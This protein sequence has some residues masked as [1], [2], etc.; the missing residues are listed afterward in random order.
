MKI[1]EQL[2]LENQ[3]CFSVYAVSRGIIKLYKQYL[4]KLDLTYTQY[5]TM[6]VLWERG[7][8]SSKELGS[9]LYLDSGTLTLLLK[10]LEKKGFV[11]RRRDI[12]DERILMVKI[13]GK[14]D[15]LKE[16]AKVIPEKILCDINLPVDELVNLREKIKK[17]LKSI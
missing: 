3:L 16:K 15:G 11:E 14:G 7:S 9:L 5:I 13:T 8:I 10:K 1:Y 12:S 17:V 4:D 2:K 6:L